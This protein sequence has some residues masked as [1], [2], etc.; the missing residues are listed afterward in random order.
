[1]NLSPLQKDRIR[2]ILKDVA[3]VLIATVLLFIGI[4]AYTDLSSL[5]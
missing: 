4:D 1:M 3:I 5:K 2:Q